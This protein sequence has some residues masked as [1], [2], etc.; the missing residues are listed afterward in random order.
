MSQV[1]QDLLG[2]SAA[3]ATGSGEDTPKREGER[4]T[5]HRDT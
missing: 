3:Q 1:L 4:E 5:S 2:P